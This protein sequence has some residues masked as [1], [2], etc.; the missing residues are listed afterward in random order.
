[1]D[2]LK[3]KLFLSVAKN[4]NFS[5]IA[6][7]FS[8][9]PSAISHMA[10]SL[11][12]ELGLKLFNRTNKG[13]NLTDDGLKLYNKFK[14]MEKAECEL[15]KEAS[16]LAIQSRYVLRI[17]AYSSIAL[18]FLPGILQSFK[19]EYPQV[20]TTIQI[21]DYM[22]DWIENGI[23]DVILADELIGNSMWQPLFEDE[24]VAVVAESEFKNKKKIN[25]S[26]IYS[27]TFIKPDEEN[28]KNYIDYKK[29]ND[30]IEVKSI[31][32]NSLI[33]MVREN[34]GITI[35]PKMSIHSLPDGVKALKLT[36]RL[37]R[38]IGIIYN[39]KKPLWVCERFARHIK[40]EIKMANSILH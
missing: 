3:I 23:A 36:P 12:D 9:T 35:L 15:F 5:E 2:S 19:Q 25:V 30:I 26:D 21:D 27:Y 32:N 24:Y 33:Y 6:K 4:K 34:L 1:M 38:T 28:L 39:T 20:K 17:G 40:N 31:E 8:Y 29:F 16:S 13:V 7:E 11:E 18:H 10:D 22:Q 14:I 37:T